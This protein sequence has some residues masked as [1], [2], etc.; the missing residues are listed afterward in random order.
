[1]LNQIKAKL[2]IKS[3]MQALGLTVYQSY[4]AMKNINNTRYDNP[5]KLIKQTSFKVK[6]LEGPILIRTIHSI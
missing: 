5:K 6:N 1:M 3:I 2:S 4:H